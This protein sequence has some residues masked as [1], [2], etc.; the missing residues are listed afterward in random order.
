LRKYLLLVFA[1]L[2]IFLA[3]CGDETST[4]PSE[5]S[6]DDV[7]EERDE[8]KESDE[9]EKEKEVSVEVAD[10]FHEKFLNNSY[11]MD[12]IGVYA[13]LKNTG[14]DPVIVPSVEVTLYDSEDNVLG[15][16]NSSEGGGSPIS[17]YV[18]DSNGSGYVTII[19][20]YEDKYEGLD[21]IDIDYEA[22]VIDAS[23]IG[24]L[25]VEKVN[26]LEGEKHEDDDAMSTSEISSEQADVTFELK[27]N[28]DED[29]DYMVGIGLYDEG[30]EFL[31]SM[32]DVDYIDVDYTV[33]SK[34][35]KSVEVIDELPVNMDDVE[36]VEVEAIGIKSE[37]D[38]DW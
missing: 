7:N 29:L 22:E 17:P 24:E 11:G 5:Q 19:I 31:G 6:S 30:D 2:L 37:N 14:E 4:E 8:V 16:N 13:E 36:R 33:G 35:T 3:A 1:S 34:D 27:N 26:L 28:G 38:D 21:H 25:D 12:S 32:I 10:Q 15:V 9:T 18:V 23:E 20:D